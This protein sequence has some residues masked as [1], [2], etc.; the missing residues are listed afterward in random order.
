MNRTNSRDDIFMPF[1]LHHPEVEAILLKPKN[2]ISL[3][4]ASWL[5]GLDADEMRDDANSLILSQMEVQKNKTYGAL[6]ENDTVNPYVINNALIMLSGN[7]ADSD[8]T[9]SRI[10]ERLLRQ[11]PDFLRYNRIS[12]SGNLPHSPIAAAIYRCY[13]LSPQKLI[14]LLLDEEISTGGRQIAAEMTGNIGANLRRQSDGKGREVYEEL[15]QA[16]KEAFLRYISEP[17]S[18]SRLDKDTLSRLVDVLSTVGVYDESMQIPLIVERL[19]REGRIDE[20]IVTEEDALDGLDGN[21]WECPEPVTNIKQLLFETVEM[22]V[23][24]R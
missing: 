16:L 9:T 13:G 7:F 18:D 22:D 6:T 17:S 15:C 2:R 11:T 14:D 12:L 21:G 24:C 20:N 8:G 1:S 5:L 4:E 3:G 10:L 23:H 19:Y